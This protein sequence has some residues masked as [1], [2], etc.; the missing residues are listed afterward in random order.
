[1]HLPV[2]N[3]GK[4]VSTCEKGKYEAGTGREI[5][6]SSGV[7]SFSSSCLFKFFFL[8]LYT[9]MI[10]FPVT[11]VLFRASWCFLHAERI[12]AGWKS[13]RK[14]RGTFLSYKICWWGGRARGAIALRAANRAVSVPS[15]S[16]WPSI[17]PYQWDKDK[18]E[19]K[20]VGFALKSTCG[21][22][23]A[24]SSRWFLHPRS[25]GK[26][27]GLKSYLWWR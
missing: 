4:F 22:Q 2:P 14:G 27:Q 25:C 17:A 26:C 5:R 6:W 10:Q 24:L 16:C 20:R 7:S 18:C 19:D 3:K 23:K 1:M 9:I 15:D 8:G 13:G 11:Q 12:Q 21:Y